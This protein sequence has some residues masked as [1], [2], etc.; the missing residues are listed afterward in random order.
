MSPHNDDEALFGSYT[1]MRRKPLVAI[2]TDS[3]MQFER[4][5]G[6]TTSQ[7]RAETLEAMRLLGAP[8]EFLG[9]KDTELSAVNLAE[10]LRDI[11]P[12]KV[13]APQPNSLN[14]QHNI[15][16]DIAYRLWPDKVIFYS[17]YTRTSLTPEGEIEIAPKYEEIR[18]KNRALDCYQSQ[19]SIN[20][21]QFLAVRG[22]SEFLN[23]PRKEKVSAILIKWK[24][25]CPSS[26]SL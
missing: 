24:I 17:T 22:K 20:N 4:G 11:H 9:I 26:L 23:D 16:G 10:R 3:W 8:V 13:Y 15:V 7:R 14:P 19:I 18:L 12:S 5:Q 21:R 2:V 25:N 6:I 1:I